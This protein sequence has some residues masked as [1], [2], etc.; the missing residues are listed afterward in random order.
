VR[1]V[2]ADV[3]INPLLAPP[4][5]TDDSVYLKW[6]MLFFAAYC[7]RS[8]DSA[9]VSWSKGRKEPAT[10][11]R[12]TQFRVV[13]ATFPWM[14]SLEARNKTVGITCGEVIDGIDEYL[15]KL[16]KGEEFRAL[17]R[18]Q[19]KKITDAYRHNRAPAHGVP[20]G[21]LGEGVRR[22]DWLCQDSMFGGIL[23]NDSL[24]TNICGDV[25]P[26]TFELKCIHRYPLTER[27]IQEQEERDRAVVTR[28]RQRSRQS[29]VSVEP[30]DDDD[31]DD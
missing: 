2:G 31:D 22:L 12:V 13:S 23:R 24:V 15:H 7:Q 18:G 30:A 5:E 14:I 21:A 8:T 6:N 9:H 29:R 20:G 11:P 10:F 1:V 3:K 25:L 16:I 26:C 17:P 28:E 27:E 19:K 4:R